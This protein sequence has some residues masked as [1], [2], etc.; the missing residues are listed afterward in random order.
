MI[1]RGMY[2]PLH[3]PLFSPLGDGAAKAEEITGPPD[4]VTAYTLAD[5][6]TNQQLD[7]EI[8]WGRPAMA[9]QYD[10]YFGATAETIALVSGDQAARVYAPTVALDS[11]YFYRIDAKNTLGTTAGTVR[12]FSTWAASDILTTN[13]GTP[14]TTSTGEY[15]EI[16]T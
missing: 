14:I 11:T 13:D 4:Q 16:T 5:G 1:S 8:R 12:S 10:V 15:I 7:V 2:R 9:Q 3:K 6:A